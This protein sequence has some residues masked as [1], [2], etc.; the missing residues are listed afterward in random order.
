MKIK[1]IKTFISLNLLICA[2]FSLC[3]CSINS[4]K[5]TINIDV[6]YLGQYIKD[7]IVFKDNLQNIDDQ[8]ILKKLYPKIDLNY[9][10]EFCVYTSAS[11][12]TAE[13][14]AIFKLKDLKYIDDIKQIIKTRINNQISNFEN[15]IPEE[16]Y[17]IKNSVINENEDKNIIT[18]ISCDT[19]NDI[20]NVLKNFYNKNS[21]QHNQ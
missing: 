14:I 15:Y 2:F 16:V 1:K 5:S 10:S 18:Y 4:K 21:E 3:A 9:I 11:G 7:N 13:E 8:D 12:A 19:P 6:N 17:K 20:E